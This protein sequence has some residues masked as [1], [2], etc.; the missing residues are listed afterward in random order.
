MVEHTYI[1]EPAKSSRAKC[2]K[3][4]EVI[5]KGELRIGDETPAHGGD[6]STTAWKHPRC[7]AFPKSK[8]SEGVTVAEFVDELIDNYSG[9][10]PILQGE[11]EVEQLIAD[12]EFTGR[13][14]GSA[15]KKRGAADD[16]P[17][18]EGSVAHLKEMRASL[19][20]EEG[21]SPAKKKLKLSEQDKAKVDIYIQY[22]NATNDE[23]KDILRWNHQLLTGNKDILMARVIDGQMRGRLA[24]CPMCIRGKL[25]LDNAAAKRV[26][27]HGFYDDDIGAR[28]T[29]AFVGSIEEAPREHPWFTEKPSE[30]EEA[31]MKEAAEALKS[32]SK[33]S[34]GDDSLVTSLED[35]AK[36]LD[37]DISTKEGKQ[38]A[39]KDLVALCKQADVDLP[40]TNAKMEIG[41]IVTGNQG[42]SASQVAKLIA[43]TY[44]FVKQN[45]QVA[46]KKAAAVEALCKN[47][48]NS[49]I[50]QVML[51]LSNCYFKEGNSNAGITYKK[52]SAAVAGLD[53]E[54]TEENAKGLGKN[55]TKVENIGKG[56]ADKIYEFVTTG[57][58]EK[59]EE[60]KAVLGL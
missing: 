31:A 19:Q 8:K 2:K 29:C 45:E 1:I 58:I 56:S 46:E 22:E 27:C 41:T 40:K 32:G 9:E 25:A 52:V 55:K 14:A 60:K 26:S 3:C 13:A 12:I 10:T 5:Q 50:V 44:G 23:L 20:E 28:H 17:P 24:R 57:K 21:T 54:I 7:F 34:G 11:G 16:G 37:W 6:Y 39:V 33:V 53:F 38:K 47:P 42:L 59:L 30:E 35:K 49:E 4:K 18:P 48:A 36:D 43:Q 15:K 51:E